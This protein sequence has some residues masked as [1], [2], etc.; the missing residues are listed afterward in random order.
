MKRYILI[1]CAL[2][3]AFALAGCETTNPDGSVSRFD[4]KGAADVINAGLSTYQQIDRQ[5]RIVGY[6]QAGNPVYR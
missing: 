2:T 5:S 1:L 3:L 6:D 4:A